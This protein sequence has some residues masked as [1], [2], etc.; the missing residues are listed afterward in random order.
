MAAVPAPPSNGDAVNATPYPNDTTDVAEIR[1]Q[2][3]RWAE[4]QHKGNKTGDEQDEQQNLANY[5]AEHGVLGDPSV[6]KA[7]L[8]GT[9]YDAKKVRD[10]LLGQ[11]DPNTV[12]VNDALNGVLNTNRSVSTKSNTVSNTKRTTAEYVDLPTPDEFLDDFDNAFQMHL[13]GLVQSGAISSEVSTFIA[14]NMKGQIFG[15][16]LREQTSQLLKGNPL[17]RVVGTNAEEKLIGSRRGPFSQDQTQQNGT[18][19]INQT[20]NTAG[21]QGG[22]SPADAAAAAARGKNTSAGQAVSQASNL[23]ETRISDQTSQDTLD[24]TNAIVQRNKLGVVANLSPLDYLKNGAAAQRLNF[25]YAGKKG[26]AVRERETATGPDSSGY[27]RR[28]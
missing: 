6:L 19:Q 28:I 25:L 14:Q 26:T 4:L 12:N 27:A 21:T 16:Y 18:E 3:L 7:V 22:L 2:F 11:T 20:D 5:L 15:D 10:E 24:T 8:E 1:K 13:N 23:N 17:Y 9:A